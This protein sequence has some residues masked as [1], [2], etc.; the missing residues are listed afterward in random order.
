M[1]SPPCVGELSAVTIFESTHNK[2]TTSKI[3]P[4]KL[5]YICRSPVLRIS[6]SG[7]LAPLAGGSRSLIAGQQSA[8]L[9]AASHQPSVEEICFP[10]KKTDKRIITAHKKSKKQSKIMYD[11]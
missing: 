7:T 8:A 11:G 10:I 2:P 6:W 5:T 1:P 4:A 3:S 9:I